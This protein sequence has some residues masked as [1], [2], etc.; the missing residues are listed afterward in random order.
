M[1]KE[2]YSNKSFRGESQ[3]LRLIENCI[4]FM[5]LFKIATLSY[6]K[7]LPKSNLEQFMR[8]KVVQYIKNKINA[9]K[10]GERLALP[11]GWLSVKTRLVGHNILYIIEKKNKTTFNK[12]RINTHAAY[13]EE[14][15]S[16]NAIEKEELSYSLMEKFIEKVI[17]Q[18]FPISLNKKISKISKENICFNLSKTG[19]NISSTPCN[20]VSVNFNPQNESYNCCFMTLFI[21]KQY[22]YK[23][24]HEK[25]M[26]QSRL[27][28]NAYESACNFRIK[29]QNF[30]EKTWG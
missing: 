7:E 12:L 21:L 29:F 28:I 27:E 11:G 25:S 6:W 19:R 24:A 18:F 9:L 30:L 20:K 14:K 15:I 13:E 5:C 23:I 4:D 10:I 8:G 3:F 1:V 22:L 16:F 26:D 17:K 2:L